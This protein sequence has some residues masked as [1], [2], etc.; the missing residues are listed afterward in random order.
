MVDADFVE[1]A[2][3]RLA[4]TS[5]ARRQPRARTASISSAA[6]RRRPEPEIMRVV[7]CSSIRS[8]SSTGSLDLPVRV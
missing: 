6:R 3:Q 4:R 7:R 1:A 2:E 5:G 8:F